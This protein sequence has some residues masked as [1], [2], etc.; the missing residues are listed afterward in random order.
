MSIHDVA[1]E[2]CLKLDAGERIE[3]L[4]Y[5]GTGGRDKTHN[6]FETSPAFKGPLLVYGKTIEPR[7]INHAVTAG[8]DIVRFLNE[9]SLTTGR[10]VIASATAPGSDPKHAVDRNPRTWWEAPA[11][12]LL[13]VDLGAGMLLD[14]V[15]IEG[16]GRF[17]QLPLNTVKA[18]LLASSNGADFKRVALLNA[19]IGGAKQP[20]THSWVDIPILPP[21][22]ARHVRLRVTDPGADGVIRVASFDVFGE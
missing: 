19:R 2:T 6:W 15:S 5:F 20:H 8:P 16:A 13:D 17:L 14:R 11:G 18:E 12:A 10:A 3:L 1:R 7:F 21:V 9:R 22:A 4:G